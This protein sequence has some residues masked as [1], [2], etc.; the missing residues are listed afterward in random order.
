ML[1]QRRRWNLFGGDSDQVRARSRVALSRQETISGGIRRR[2]EVKNQF[3]IFLHVHPL[4][5]SL[6]GLQ[7]VAPF[8][9]TRFS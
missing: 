8:A 9:I 4:L 1:L 7:K 2:L 3:H 6:Q 5:S